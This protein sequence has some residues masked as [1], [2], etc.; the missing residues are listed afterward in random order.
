MGHLISIVSHLKI[1]SVNG[2]PIYHK[3]FDLRQKDV[4]GSFSFLP[5]DALT[6]FKLGQQKKGSPFSLS[7]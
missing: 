2:I 5:A 3:I 7:L 1:V 4:L 6:I